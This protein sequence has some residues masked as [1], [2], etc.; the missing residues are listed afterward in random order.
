V[1]A[2]DDA[3]DALLAQRAADGDELAFAVIVRR[4]APYLR[5]LTTG[6]LRSNADVDDV[7]QDAFITA[8]DKLPDLRD[9]RGLRSWLAAIAA[10]KATDRLR[11][12]RD[13]TPLDDVD[14]VAPGDDPAASAELSSQ[15]AALGRAL[16][17]LPDEVRITWTL[18]EV[19]GRSYE[20]IAAD[21]DVPV[22]TVRGRLA[23]ARAHLL[24]RMMEWRT[25]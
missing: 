18:R 2:L 9:G 3:A 20:Q 11:R 25:S 24:D 7:V 14:P 19:S 4:H 16:A 6:L 1:S 15:M 5:A 13:Q 10:R 8:W 12:R 21:L 17:D 22:S 23:R